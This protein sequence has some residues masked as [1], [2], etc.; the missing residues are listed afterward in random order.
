MWS[1]FS[2][3]LQQKIVFFSQNLLLKNNM[4]QKV[5]FCVLDHIL[6]VGR[7]QGRKICHFSCMLVFLKLSDLVSRITSCRM[8]TDHH[9]YFTTEISLQDVWILEGK[10]CLQI[11]RACLF[12]II[13]LKILQLQYTLQNQR[14]SADRIWKIIKKCM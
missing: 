8:K 14:I 9:F 5:T 13:L 12:Q 1:C 2:F 7:G 11:V 10:A 4:T 3:V 6:R